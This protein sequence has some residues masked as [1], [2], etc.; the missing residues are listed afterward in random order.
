MWQCSRFRVPGSGFRVTVLARSV[1]GLFWT[2]E[3]HEERPNRNDLA[4]PW[5]LSDARCRLNEILVAPFM[6]RVSR[7]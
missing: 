3:M 2:S 5:I 6:R 1:A 4:A 7:F